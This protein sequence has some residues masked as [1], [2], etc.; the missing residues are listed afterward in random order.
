MNLEA[1]QNIDNDKLDKLMKI[2]A[3]M[4]DGQIFG[5]RSVSLEQF[6]KEYKSYVQINRASKTSEGVKLRC[7]MNI[8]C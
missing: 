7:T 1:S 6:I 8:S 5:H 2:A 3:I 4:G